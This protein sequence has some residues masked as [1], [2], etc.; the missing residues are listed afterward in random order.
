MHQE[1]HASLRLSLE[2]VVL[3]DQ[4]QARNEPVEPVSCGLYVTYP[5]LTMT[6]FR[7]H[8]SHVPAMPV[9]ASDSRLPTTS[10][11]RSLNAFKGPSEYVAGGRTK[12]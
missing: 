8:Q 4:H 1:G 10:R 2:A 11:S 12:R 9:A 5:E 6:A 3:L 7:R